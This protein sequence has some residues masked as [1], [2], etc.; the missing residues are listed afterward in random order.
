M[1]H[2]GTRKEPSIRNLVVVVLIAMILTFYAIMSFTTGD[3]LWFSYNFS[4]LPNEVVLHCYGETTD[5]Y[6]G[7]F[8]FSKLTEIMNKSMSG[9]KRWDPLTMSE[10]TYEEYRN[11]PR[12]LV[13]EFFYPEPVRVHSTYSLYSSVDNLVVPLDGRHSQT[14]AVFGQNNGV[15]TGGSLHIESADGF[16]EY[17]NNMD[18][19]SV[20]VLGAN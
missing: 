17:L 5:I 20:G 8:H 11:S 13:V 15:P 10:A 1:Q 18:L 12:M 9:R 7:S 2:V 4:A 19:C 16:R 6:P 14:N 3:W